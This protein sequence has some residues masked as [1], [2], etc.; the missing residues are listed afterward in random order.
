MSA[1]VRPAASAAKLITMRC[2]AARAGGWSAI[3]RA[4]ILQVVATAN[5]RA[6][7]LAGIALLGQWWLR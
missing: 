1:A 7:T 6:H 4:S 2:S 3:P 5:G